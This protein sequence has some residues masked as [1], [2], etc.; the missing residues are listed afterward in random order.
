MLSFSLKT[1][2]G[3]EHGSLGALGTV[4]LCAFETPF[5]IKRGTGTFSVIRKGVCPV[6]GK[7]RATLL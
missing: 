2:S 6:V 1:L 4:L 3:R 5:R 7:I